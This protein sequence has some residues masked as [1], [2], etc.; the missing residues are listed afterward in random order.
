MRRGLLYPS[1]RMSGKL[2]LGYREASGM[3]WPL[4][5]RRVHGH[6]FHRTVT[7]PA[8]GEPPAYCMDGKPE[9]FAQGRVSASYLHLHWAGSPEIA[10]ELVAALQENQCA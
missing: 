3:G 1:A 4:V 5:G 9:G 7:D 2:T 8:A 10:R 6:E